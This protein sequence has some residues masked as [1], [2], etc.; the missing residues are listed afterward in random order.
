M[1]TPLLLLGICAGIASTAQTIELADTIYTGNS[2]TYYVLDSNA[3]NYAGTTGT[4]VNWD[5]STIGAYDIPPNTNAVIDAEGS[6][7]DA[8]FPDAHYNE[9]FENGILSYLSHNPTDNETIV[10]GFV[11]EEAS[12][13]FVI[14]YDVDPLISLKYPMSQGD[15]YIDDISGTVLTAGS[16]FAISG[17]ATVSADGSGSLQV[18]DNTYTSVIRVY[19][20][21]VVSGTTPVGTSATF[22]RESYFYYDIENFNQPVFIHGKIAVDA[23]LL[24][25]FEFSTV[26]GRDLITDYVGIE[27]NKAEALNL[28]VYPNPV[29]GNAATITVSEGAD[30]L[31]VLNTLGQSVLTINNPAKVE[32]VNMADLKTGVYFVQV[33]KGSALR[34]EKFVVK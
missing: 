3:V 12:G 31:T 4:G 24:G 28:S 15:S 26:Y 14:K 34:T 2:M 1:K 13:T 6:E 17:T 21:E 9:N 32:T 22:T 30:K 7:Y 5:Y 16:S 19:T 25:D 18:G 20:K 33:Q 10:H 23:G 29:T 27:E 11:F 8:E